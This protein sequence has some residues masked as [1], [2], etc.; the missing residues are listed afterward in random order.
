MNITN[1]FKKGNPRVQK[2]KH[3]INQIIKRIKLLR[4]TSAD[5]ELV[6]AL[7]CL[8]PDSRSF[9]KHWCK[10]QESQ[11]KLKWFHPRETFY[12]QSEIKLEKTFRSLQLC[13]VAVSFV[14]YKN[15]AHFSSHFSN[16]SRLHP[17]KV[18]FHVSFRKCFIL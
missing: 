18:T 4:N 3:S 1:R 8:K 2:F 17:V 12:S 10:T 5:D 14:K 9:T 13:S 7:P 15:G 16:Y 6:L 11:V